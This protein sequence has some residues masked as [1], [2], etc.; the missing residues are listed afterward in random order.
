MSTRR[1]CLDVQGPKKATA[2][3]QHFIGLERH[4]LQEHLR[5]APDMKLDT[6]L[7]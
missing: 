4:D 2:S 5:H 6:G 1:R 3:E 7:K